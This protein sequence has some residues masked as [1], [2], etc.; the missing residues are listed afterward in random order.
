MMH[1]IRML[2]YGLCVASVTSVIWMWQLS[3]IPEAVS[4]RN[5]V[6]IT[7]VIQHTDRVPLG[8]EYDVTFRFSKVRDDCVDG[9]VVR[10]MWGNNGMYTYKIQDQPVV[11]HGVVDEADIR[12]ML[13]TAPLD[14]RDRRFQKPGVWSIKS[15]VRYMCPSP[16]GGME[17]KEE[18]FTT[19]AFE[20]YDVG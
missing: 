20:V 14:Q 8:G 6:I 9:K 19:P 5:P 3:S 18:N 16:D 17:I 10:H 11:V 4:I 15:T 13:P 1:A 7:D 2:L 12:V